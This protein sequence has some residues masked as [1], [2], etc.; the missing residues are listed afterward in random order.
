MSEILYPIGIQDFEKIRQGGYMYVDKTQHIHELARTGVYYFL[1]RPRRFGKSLLISTMEAYFSGR[2][3]LFKGLAMEKLEKDWTAYPV[4]HL[5]L[6]ARNYDEEASLVIELNKHL[7]KWEA[8]YGDNYKDRSVEERFF[9]IVEQAFQKTGQRV[10]VLIDEYDKPLLQTIG[11]ENLQEKYRSQ[12]KAFYSVLKSQDRYIRFAFL[13]GVTK[14]SKVSVFSDLN[15]LKDISMNAK[16]IDICGMTEA[17]I[18]RYFEPALYEFAEAIGK[19]YEETCLMLKEQYDG[20]HFT[21]NSPGIYNPFSLL[22]ALQDKG[23][24][25]Y[26]FETGTPTFLVQ[27][28]K[29]SDYNLERLCDEEQETSVLNS[30][31]HLRENPI[32]VLYQSGYLTI[33]DHD[34]EFGTYKLG[35]PNK[36][37]KTGFIKYLLPYYLPADNSASILTMNNFVR[38]VRRGD[39]E[40]FMRRM[41][42]FFANTNY[43]IVGEM[44]KY[45]HNALY[46]V[47]MM[48]GFYTEVERNTSWGSIDIVVKTKDYI[49][50]IECKLDSSAKNAIQQIVDKNYAAPYAMDPRRLFKIGVNFSS[51][52][53]GIDDYLIQ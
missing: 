40:T 31:E 13:T 7:E 35:F 28:L 37:V 45:F 47:F 48:M 4:L 2:K 53:R 38:D 20:Y 34:P 30:M 15:N 29:E 12:L 49:Y 1:S 11:N 19:T 50:L 10:V 14:F 33:R 26:W 32:P 16:Y 43:K 46:L 51:K 25:D 27:L 9:H 24:N 5:D 42:A 18:H 21:M 44:E 22:N 6:N 41:Q 3:E 17:E 39:P 23:L 52:T 8:L 36:E